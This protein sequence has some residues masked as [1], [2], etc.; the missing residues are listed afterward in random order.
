[1]FYQIFPERFANGDKRNDPPGS[2]PWGSQPTIDNYM[3]GD[4]DGVTQ[5]LDHLQKLGITAIYFNPIFTS[6]S[7]HK[8]HTTD[9]MHV[10]P[11]FGGDAA[12]KRL[13]TAAHKRNIK[14]LLDGVF[15]HTGD[16][17]PF[18][19]EASKNG[20]KGK[21]WDWYKIEGLPIVKQPKPNY[22]AWWGLPSLPKLQVAKNPA[23]ASYIYAVEEH[24]LRMGIDGWRLDVPNEIDSD[25]FWQGFRKR[26][27]AINPQAYI[28]GEIWD[29]ADRWLQ[30]DQFDAV[31]NYQWRDAALKFFISDAMKAGSFDAA[32]EGLRK[33][34]HPAVTQAMFNVLDS[35]DTSRLL[36]DAGGDVS[37]QKLA[38][39]FQLTYVG[40][41]CIYYGD[42]I[43]L[44]GGK[45]P[46]DR[47]CM[48]WDSR[49]WNQDLLGF[50]RTVI[51]ARK[52]HGALRTGSFTTLYKGDEDGVY[53]YSRALGGDHAIVV[54]NNSAQ[55]RT[56]KFDAGAGFAKASLVDVLGGENVKATGSSFTLRLD[57]RQG[58]LLLPRG[59]RR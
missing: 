17:H 43:G 37:R 22:E 42:E 7:N 2:Q 19:L 10:D 48:P 8:Y 28:V 44:Q 34:Y 15:N 53:A 13:L 50:Y 39:L 24:W 33:R 25:A 21:Y 41:P 40:A 36:T 55:Q 30:G 27:H 3:G 56:V 45:D 16:S 11:H 9:Y 26:A 6:D 1:V 57:P 12:F 58:M 32:L 46:D 54:L 59:E 51:A 14:V 31:M 49:T 35:H 52:Q 23:V 5:H 38:A 29:P 4:L 20:P 47:R 18:F